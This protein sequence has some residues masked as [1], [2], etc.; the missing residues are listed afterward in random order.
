MSVHLHLTLESRWL[1]APVSLPFFA[2]VALAEGV[3]FYHS[4]SLQANLQDYSFH[5]TKM[6]S[7]SPDQFCKVAEHH[8]RQRRVEYP[9]T[10][11]QLSKPAVYVSDEGLPLLEPPATARCVPPPI[12]R[13]GWNKL[14][15]EPE[16]LTD[17]VADALIDMH[18]EYE[19]RRVEDGVSETSIV[20]ARLNDTVFRITVDESADGSYRISCARLSGDTFSY[21]E[22]FRALKERL[23]DAVGDAVVSHQRP[24]TSV[25][26]ANF[27]TGVKRPACAALA[28]PSKAMCCSALSVAN[29]GASAQTLSAGSRP[30]QP[31]AGH[32]RCAALQPDP[33]G[34]CPHAN[35]TDHA[36]SLEGAS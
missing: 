30:V 33:S 12:K 13:L 9:L 23:S 8:Q 32:D 27:R 19:V 11:L 21:H 14:I 36:Q 17:R 15:L 26:S 34:A 7:L 28:P 20:S 5:M 4:G 6:V 1:A 24:L 18:A 10:A 3:C 2:L 35:P 29:V 31:T 22:A 25:S 16:Y